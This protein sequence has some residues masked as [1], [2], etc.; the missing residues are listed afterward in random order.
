MGCCPPSGH[1]RHWRARAPGELSLHL[2][3]LVGVV[4]AVEPRA[5]QLVVSLHPAV[6]FRQAQL[7]GG[8]R[9][10]SVRL[11]ASLSVRHGEGAQ[12]VCAAHLS[13]AS[14]WL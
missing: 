6:I 12:G 14:A 11:L 3:G 13:A 1:G 2:E 10:W 8:G 5:G 7:K 4:P 9:L